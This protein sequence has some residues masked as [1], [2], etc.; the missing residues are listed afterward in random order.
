MVQMTETLFDDSFQPGGGPGWVTPDY[1]PEALV[2]QR[3]FELPW[4]PVTGYDR[5]YLMLCARE[6][7]HDT[8]FIAMTSNT[9][10]DYIQ[11]G[12]FSGWA[13][14]GI[15][16]ANYNPADHPDIDDEDGIIYEPYREDPVF[17]DLSRTDL[18]SRN[19]FV[20]I[21]NEIM[22]FQS[23]EAYGSGWI[24]L[25]G[26]VRGVLN[27]TQTSHTTGAEVWLFELSNNILTGIT[28]DDFYVKMLPYFTSE[29]VSEAA[30]D[31]EHVQPT[32]KALE[33]WPPHRLVVT[34]SGSSCTAEWWPTNKESVGAGM[35][36]TSQLDSDPMLYDQDFDTIA[37]ASSLVVAGT[38]RSYTDASQHTF[39]VRARRN[40]R[41]S[42]Y[43]S[44][45]VGTGDGDYYSDGW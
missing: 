1:S 2:H 21:G 10:V 23:S 4:N 12:S 43:I 30:A 34:R 44:V 32:D 37:N 45:T 6:N 16:K 11:H 42:S 20:L 18:F 28:S 39:Q 29:I 19:R 41:Y 38:T 26:V 35:A 17:A 13:Q 31:A 3:V 22:R 25:T 15:L 7:N 24:R 14:R 8:G 40:G 33:V 5:A 27:T 9:G 36:G